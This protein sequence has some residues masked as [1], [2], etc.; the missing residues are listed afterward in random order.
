MKKFNL[1][2]FLLSQQSLILYRSFMKTI[3]KIPD[4]QTKEEIANQVRT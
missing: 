4:P 1:K 3:Q 2:Y